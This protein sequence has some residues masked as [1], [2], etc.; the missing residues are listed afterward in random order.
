MGTIYQSIEI[1]SKEKGID[2]Q[3]VLDAVKDAMLVAARKHYRTE[4]DLVAELDEKTGSILIYSVK[5]VVETVT[6]ANRELSL[7]QARRQN[8]GVEVDSEIRTA[9]NT[10]SLGRISA[11]TA[12]QVILQKVREAERETIYSEYS[13]R[14]GELVNCT[15]KRVEGMDFMVD[16]GK[17]EARLPKKEQSKTES[18][19]VG[20]RVRC[21][22][23]SVEKAGKSAGVTVSRAAPELVM[24]LFEQEVPE[25]YDGTVSIKACAR[26]AGE[27][28]KIA[29]SSRDRD[30]DSVGACVGMRGMRVQSIIRELRGEKI[31]IIQYSDDP[32]VFATNALSPAKITR[33]AIVE[34]SNKHMEV[35]VD[36][37]QLSLAI[38]KKGQN[39]RLGARL[40]GWRIDI[41]SEEEKRQEVE[42]EMAA[43]VVPGAPVTVLMDHGLNEK[44]VDKLAEAGIPT[45]EKLG[46]MTPEQLEAIPG[47][48]PKMI[49][50]IQAAVVNYYGQFEVADEGGQVGKEQEPASGVEAAPVEKELDK[51]S[52]DEAVA[53]EAASE[54]DVED[55][56]D[57]DDDASEMGDSESPESGEEAP[58]ES[59][60][61]TLEEARL[62]VESA[63]PESSGSVSSEGLEEN[64]SDRIKETE[65]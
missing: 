61:E 40:L 25:I 1:L 42:S 9:M 20:E 26:E 28:T 45:V 49:E 16:L 36:D 5:K 43:L 63:P 35:I 8:P 62:P 41:K 64:E 4:E 60:E 46:S 29:V 34:S 3:I 31:D 50:K 2:P 6:D 23:K 54:G 17:T 59:A 7:E 24:R 47:I 53:D 12:K 38:G 30:V 48:G 11:Q 14:V 22:I 33:V 56:V 18:F 21:V 44:I 13:G 51:V 65:I 39:V 10:D 15:V 19:A 55:E 37:S 57:I 52:A 27:R 32:V 58:D